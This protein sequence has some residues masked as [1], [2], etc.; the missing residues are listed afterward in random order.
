MEF[1]YSRR[2]EA[3][4]FKGKE[5]RVIELIEYNPFVNNIHF[6]LN[7]PE[8]ARIPVLNKHGERRNPNCIGTAFFIAGISSLGYPYH[9]YDNELG[10]HRVKDDPN[11]SY[12]DKLK[13]TLSRN[14]HN[15]IPGAFVYSLMDSYHVSIYLGAIEDMDIF[16]S[17]FGSIGSKRM[18]G[19][20][21]ER[22]FGNPMFYLPT[23]LSR[24]TQ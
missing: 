21:T 10:G 5:G 23:S 17:Q 4:F 1:N 9:A 11:R 6:L 13:D 24:S 15:K 2:E 20:Q 14:I 18:F 7:N 8:L 19:T 22:C 12:E 3:E 16:F